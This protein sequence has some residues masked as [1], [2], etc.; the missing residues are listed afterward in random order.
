M[1]SSAH[2]PERSLYNTIMKS[3]RNYCHTKQHDRTENLLGNYDTNT[4]K[5]FFIQCV[6][7]THA[8]HNTFFTCKLHYVRLLQLCLIS[9]LKVCR[10][11]YSARYN[12]HPS[13][14]LQ[15]DQMIQLQRISSNR[16]YSCIE[17]GSLPLHNLTSLH[18]KELNKK[19]S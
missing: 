4:C 8:L 13:L 17:I 3:M 11:S 6:D 5:Y 9:Y 19:K 10:L 15:E 7:G 16:C 1:N 18:Q 14:H 2:A 12:P